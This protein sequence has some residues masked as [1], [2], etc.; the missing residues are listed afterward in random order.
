MN[1]SGCA[2]SLKLT[3]LRLFPCFAGKQQTL[4]GEKPLSA[5]R[6]DGTCWHSLRCDGL[7]R[8]GQTE[9]FASIISEAAC[10]TK[11]QAER[12]RGSG[13]F[14]AVRV[15]IPLSPPTTAKLLI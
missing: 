11:E 8:A 14:R 15:R 1:S 7:S 5:I 4:C 9:K 10:H 3:L 2:S 12:E 13:H 6:K